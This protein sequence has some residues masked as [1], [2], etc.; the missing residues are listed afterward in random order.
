MVVVLIVLISVESIGMMPD[1][2]IATAVLSRNCEVRSKNSKK[3]KKKVMK[4][5]SSSKSELKIYVLH[6][7]I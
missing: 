2:S 5:S 7:N 4:T 1:D 3:K 6:N